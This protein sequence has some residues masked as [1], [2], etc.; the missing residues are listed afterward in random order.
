M[1]WTLVTLLFLACM[2]DT[3]SEPEPCVPTS[4]VVDAG[5]R[6][7]HMEFLAE[8]TAGENVYVV[9]TG[10]RALVKF[11]DAG[12]FSFMTNNECGSVEWHGT[13]VL[14]PIV[15]PALPLRAG[16]TRV[17]EISKFNYP[18]TSLIDDELQID[19]RPLGPFFSTYANP[20]LAPRSTADYFAQFEPK[21]AGSVSS[22]FVVFIGDW[23]TELTVE[24]LAE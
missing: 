15:L 20:P 22:R 13:A 14:I 9:Q 23:S 1:R 4:Q 17:G 3:P 16:A 21:E 5:V 7:Q 24:A 6:W 19:V 8:A 12:A 10:K 18:I 11:I 2:P